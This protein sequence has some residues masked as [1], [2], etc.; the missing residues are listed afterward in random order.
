M[1]C[2]ITLPIKGMLAIG[3]KL[4][5]QSVTNCG[6]LMMGRIMIY[7]MREGRS[8]SLSEELTL[9]MAQSTITP[10]EAFISQAGQGASTKVVDLQPASTF[11]AVTGS[12]WTKQADTEGA[13]V[14][15]PSTADWLNCWWSQ[16]QLGWPRFASFFGRLQIDHK[17]NNNKAIIGKIVNHL[18]EFG[19]SVC[20]L[21]N[22]PDIKGL[23]CHL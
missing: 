14:V 6:H 17:K 2:S 12:N 8:P 11:F 18:E 4:L 22:N 23:L 21:P 9:L 16:D 15:P 7:F 20:S 19:L 5:R 10:L 13:A 1:T 3:K